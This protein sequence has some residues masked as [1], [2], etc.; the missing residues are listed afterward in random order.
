[1]KHSDKLLFE[2]Q[3]EDGLRI[4]LKRRSK[5]GSTSRAARALGILALSLDFNA[6]G[7]GRVHEKALVNL[8]ST[9]NSSD[10]QATPKTILSLSSEGNFLASALGPIEAGHKSAL[11]KARNALS[12]LE[13]RLKR[14]S[15][16]NN[17]LGVEY[18][19]NIKQ[20]QLLA[21][22]FLQALED[23]RMEISR[24]LHDQVAQ[25]LAGINVGL[26][27]LKKVSIIDQETL[28]ERIGH[29]QLLVE[30]SVESIHHYARKLRPVMLDDLGL[31]PSIR[32]FIKNLPSENGLRIRFKH[33]LEPHELSNTKR[34]VLYRVAQEAVTNVIRHAKATTLMVRLDS[35]VD[36]GVILVV[37]DN[38]KSFNLE[39]ILKSNISKRLG[40]LGMRERVEMV[41]GVFDI[42]SASGKGTKVR[43]E[44]FNNNQ[45]KSEG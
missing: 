32:S 12:E 20:S 29:T 13:N 28:E 24:E 23:E 5:K 11:T 41:G 10:P 27:A 18:Q 25:I 2:K 34:T 8:G 14:E 36:D 45:I 7:I 31:I 40:L 17:Q 26:A 38:G 39:R 42:Q 43:V 37:K 4:Y 44:I 16:I 19:L 35:C 3:Y 15:Y 6:V 21:H 22:Q 30:Q 9:A 33:G 1:M